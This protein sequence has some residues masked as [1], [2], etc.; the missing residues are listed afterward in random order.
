MRRAALTSSHPLS[1]DEQ[2]REEH[3][4]E[5]T[6]STKFTSG[7]A[8]A[9]NPGTE[10]SFQTFRFACSP[11]TLSLC[12]T[13]LYT[14]P[15]AAPANDHKPLSQFWRPE[16]KIKLWM[17]PRSL[18]ALGEKPAWPRPASRAPGVPGLGLPACS[19]CLCGQVAF[20][21]SCLSSVCLLSGHMHGL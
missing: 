20:S 8:A 17:G 2:T 6:R 10:L 1:H 7:T 11:V 13:P 3:K 16:S 18:T 14:F 19:L 5:Q 21:F 12:A 9:A 15:R 4:R